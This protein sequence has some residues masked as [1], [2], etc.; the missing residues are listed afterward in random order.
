MKLSKEGLT[1]EQWRHYKRFGHLPDE[2]PI[3]Q[4]VIQTSKVEYNGP[5]ISVL[6]V[7]FGTKYGRDYVE[8]LRNMVARHLTIPY[9]FYC[10]T[11]D[12]HPID[13]VKSL[14]YPNQG[15][16]KGWWHKVHMFDPDLKLP[17]RILYMDLDVIIHDNINKLVLDQGQDFLGIRDFNRK[18]NPKWNILN[19]SVMTWPAGLH[20]DIFTVFKSDQSRAQRLHGDQDWIWQV[21]K[22][23]IKFFPES[24]IQSYKWEIRDRSE[25]TMGG[26]RR[27]FKTTRDVTIPKGCSI[28]VFHGDPNPHDITD[29]YVVDNWR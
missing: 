29:P 14:V 27:F 28:C 16:V 10:L 20:P 12:Q 2:V 23:R 1:K 11:D 7:R 21:A 3:E 18:F 24:W 19:S 4:P 6:C 17:G 26:G 15:Y 9:E 5:I 8:K 25:L 13:G 22:T